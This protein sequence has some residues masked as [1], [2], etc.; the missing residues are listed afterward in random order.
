MVALQLER[1]FWEKATLL[2]SEHHRAVDRPTPDRFS[3][4]YSDTAA[5]ANHPIASKAVAQDH[6]RERVVNWKSLFFASAWARYDLARPGTF[7]LVPAAA[8]AP[9]LRRDYQA[10][11]DMYLVEPMP[12][13]RIL[14]TLAALEARINGGAAGDSTR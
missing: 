11:R 14:D 3:R 8:R 12:F 7:R 6:L 13:D 9:E 4:H 5:L 2:H 1:T 10:M